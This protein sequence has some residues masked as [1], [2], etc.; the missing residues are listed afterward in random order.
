VDDLLFNDEAGA[1]TSPPPT[2]APPK[3]SRVGRGLTVV[4]VVAVVALLGLGTGAFYVKGQLNPSGPPGKT[5]RVD[6]PKGSSTARIATLLER[7]HVITSAR[8]FKLY[9]KVKGGGPFEAGLYELRQRSS[10]A[11]VVTAMEA[12]PA[13][14]P[15]VNITIPEGLVLDQVAS[16]IARVKRFDAQ[17]FLAAASSGDVRSKFQPAGQLSLEGLLFPDTYR[18]EDRESEQDVLIRMVAT[19]EQVADELGYDQAQQKVGYSA[20]QAIIVASLVESEAKDDA[21][22]AKIARVIY[23]R[24]AKKIPLGI[25]ATFYFALPLDRRGTG[26]RQSDLDRPGPYNTRKNVGL[27]PTP[28]ALPGRASLEAAL[29]PAPGPWLYYVLKDART[30]AFTDDYN[31]FL[32]DKR[33]AQEKGLIP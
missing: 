5:V 8:V 11:A 4:A 12:G 3:A 22:R 2:P 29:N 14:P 23:N 10:M 31:Q 16:R 9:L 26:L 15:A 27:V 13:L 32:R 18:V 6:V 25:D 28:I 33:T 7:G 1:S 24:L 19:F 21:D 30:H 20:Y 17:R